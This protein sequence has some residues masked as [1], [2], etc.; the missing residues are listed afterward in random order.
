M[1]QKENPIHLPEHDYAP[2][3]RA[4]VSW[5]GDRYLLAEQ[6][7]RRAEPKQW[8]G[9]GRAVRGPAGNTRFTPPAAPPSVPTAAFA[10]GIHT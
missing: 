3:L 10:K 9:D 5:L 2:A 7:T 8:H 6:V 1:K 4:A